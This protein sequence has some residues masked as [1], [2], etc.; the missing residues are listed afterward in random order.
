MSTAYHSWYYDTRV[1]L[2]TTFLGVLCQKSVSDMWNY[3]EILSEL[4]P[5]LI[6]E[7]GAF[8]GGSALYFATIAKLVKPEALVL[9]V[10]VDLS[11]IDPRV[12]QEQAIEFFESS[13]T[14]AAVAARILALRAQRPGPVFFIVDSDHRKEHVLGELELL[15]GVTRTG[16]YVV[17]EDG[18]LNGHPVMPGWGEGPW[19]ALEEYRRLHPDDYMRDEVRESKFGFTFA[20]KGFLV[21][22]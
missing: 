17:V 12:K 9:S 3:Q 15:R 11:R 4:K 22:R 7:F 5:G 2:T 21:R 6:V 14:D 16:D 18:N 13:S 1:W 10:D 20:P 19:E 8:N